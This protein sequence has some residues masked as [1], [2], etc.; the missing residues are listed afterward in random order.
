MYKITGELALKLEMM[1]GS[2][3][4]ATALDMHASFEIFYK[5]NIMIC[6]DGASNNAVNS[7]VEAIN[8]RKTT[9]ASI[10]HARQAVEAMK[11]VFC[12]RAIRGAKQ[13]HENEGFNNGLQLQQVVQ[14]QPAELD[15]FV[16]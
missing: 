15:L 7:K 10:G 11:T 3:V 12:S 1:S 9:S 13:E 14:F 5:E 6:N 2:E 4:S 16:M 8:E